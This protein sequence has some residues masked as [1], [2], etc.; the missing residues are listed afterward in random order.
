MPKKILILGGTKEA[1]ELA[2]K[3]VAEGADVTTSLAG[4]TREP[5]PIA[6][7]VRSGGFGGAEKMAEWII[8]NGIDLVVDATHPFATQISANAQTACAKA[9]VKLDIK[10]RQPWQKQ[11][12]DIWQEVDTL[13]EAANILPKGAHV[14]LALGSQHL[15]V[16]ETREDVHFLVR[17]VDAPKSALGLPNHKLVLGR[18]SA[19]WRDEANLLRDEKISHIVCRNSG[20]SGAYAK[21]VA[22]RSLAIPVILSKMPR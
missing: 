5:R 21:I 11:D 20:G 12:G 22:A 2:Q 18:P 3:R 1:A 7:K 16:F 15:H 4:R 8:A 14:L 19:D 6:G 10:Q 13:V 9:N 17:M